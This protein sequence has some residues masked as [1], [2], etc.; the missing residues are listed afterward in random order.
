MARSFAYDYRIILL[1][2]PGFPFSFL[3]FSRS[4]RSLAFTPASLAARSAISW[5]ND[6]NVTVMNNTFWSGGTMLLHV[7]RRYLAPGKAVMQL[8]DNIF[9]CKQGG[10]MKFGH[11][12]LPAFYLTWPNLDLSS[13]Y[14]GFDGSFTFEIWDAPSPTQYGLSQW[15]GIHGLELNSLTGDPKF[16]APS[17][18]DF[19]LRSSYGRWNPAGMGC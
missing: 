1:L 10:T 13:D 17:Q 15:R 16:A 5:Q 14:N 2:V 3:N 19:H 18:G 8:R 4:E 6:W 7:H 12:Y 9:S 11:H